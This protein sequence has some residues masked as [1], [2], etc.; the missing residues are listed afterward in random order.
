MGAMVRA[1][2]S[3]EK[4]GLCLRDKVKNIIGENN[5]EYCLLE[6]YKNTPQRISNPNSQK[7]VNVLEGAIRGLCMENEISQGIDSH[8][9]K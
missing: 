6:E 4:I 8:T 9:E 3:T 7:L 1:F 5:Q 2:E